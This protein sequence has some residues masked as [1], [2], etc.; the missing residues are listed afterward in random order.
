MIEA[1]RQFGDWILGRGEASITIPIFDGALKP[2]QILEGA[3]VVAEFDD[4]ERH[5]RRRSGHPGRRRQRAVRAPPGRRH[6]ARSS[7]P[8][9]RPRHVAPRASRCPRR[10][11][12]RR[13]GRQGSAGEG[14]GARR[15]RLDRSGERALPGRQCHRPAGRRTPGGHRRLAAAALRPLGP[16]SDGPRRQRPAD[17]GRSEERP[18]A[19]TG[20]RPRI[21]LRR[22]PDER[23]HPGLGELASS[24]GRGRQ[25]P[26]A[27]GADAAAGLSLARSF[28]RPAAASGSRPSPRAP[29]SSSSCCARLPSGGG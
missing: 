3:E 19:R 15:L 13:A 29:S 25:R 9:L 12:R 1:M 14:R 17:R 8:R 23:R 5:R 2:N 26:A 7:P 20:A 27:A 4:A 18:G 28:R 10:R 11:H 16:R 6:R 24:A 22:L 21:R